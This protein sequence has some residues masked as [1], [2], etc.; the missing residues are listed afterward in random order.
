MALRKR[1]EWTK[2]ATIK[3]CAFNQI[4]NKKSLSNINDDDQIF[5]QRW[6]LYWWVQHKGKF[7]SCQWKAFS[8][9]IQGFEEN[10]WFIE[11]LM[12]KCYKY[13][14]DESPLPAFSFLWMNTKIWEQNV[15]TQLFWPLVDKIL[16][17]LWTYH[18]QTL[19]K[20][21]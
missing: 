18:N 16:F 19:Y 4:F 20:A 2:I 7:N 11:D 21:S 17:V 5:K 14:E 3:T 6:E 13:I 9:L 8:S 10:F 15:I 1:A 12:D